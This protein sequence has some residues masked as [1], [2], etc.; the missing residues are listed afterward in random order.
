MFLSPPQDWPRGQSNTADLCAW[1]RHS[2]V[3]SDGIVTDW[4]V[5]FQLPSANVKAEKLAASKTGNELTR[6][7]ISWKSALSRAGRRPHS[8]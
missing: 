6:S 1:T 8:R 3:S 5:V 2:G 4:I 7:S